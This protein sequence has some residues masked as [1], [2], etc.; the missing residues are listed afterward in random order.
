MDNFYYQKYLKYRNKYLSLKNDIIM[1]DTN[2]RNKYLSLMGG[3]NCPKIGY[4]QHKGECWHDSLSIALLYSDILSDHHQALFDNPTFNASNIVRRDPSTFKEH[5]MPINIEPEDYELFLR[6]S[7]DYIN[8]LHERYI[9]DKKP[10]IKPNPVSPDR[11]WA[12]VARSPQVLVRQ[13]SLAMSL[14]CVNTIFDISSINNISPKEYTNINHGGLEYHDYATVATINYFLTSY[15]TN[16]YIELDKITIDGMIV[17]RISY[18]IKRLEFLKN[19]IENSHAIILSLIS[20]TEHYSENHAVAFIKCDNKYYFYDNNGISNSNTSR[21]IEFNWKDELTSRIDG[22]IR[23]FTNYKISNIIEILETLFSTSDI[24]YLIYILSDFFSGKINILDKINKDQDNIGSIGKPYLNEFYIEEMLFLTLKDIPVD[25][26]IKTQ[27]LILYNDDLLINN[28]NNKKTI[29]FI[30]YNISVI[31]H[32]DVFKLFKNALLLNNSTI[33]DI[34]FNYI[35]NNFPGGVNAVSSHNEILLFAFLSINNSDDDETDYSN[36]ELKKHYIREL[37]NRN[38]KFTTKNVNGMDFLTFI[39]QTDTLNNSP[40]I[41]E[42]SNI[43]IS[44]IMNKILRETPSLAQLDIILNE[45]FFKN[46][47]INKKILVKKYKKIHNIK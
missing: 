47:A 40:Y 1:T 42:I 4:S 30:K 18:I 6:L 46:I 15:N 17:G 14:G 2:H 45:P 34:V 16:K 8:S 39:R 5:L 37:I 35:I 21:A 32:D 27:L 20:E 13:E 10:P 19:T 44:E 26:S 9:N 29:D 33:A 25:I 36:L 23:L 11:R 3:A 41:N 28:Y 22:I 24:N 7:E 31:K 38:I 12:D 43:I